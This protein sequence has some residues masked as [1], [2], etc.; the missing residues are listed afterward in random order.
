MI[1]EHRPL[2]NGTTPVSRFVRYHPAN[3]LSEIWRCG[4][5]LSSACHDSGR[6]TRA[7]ADRSA[8]KNKYRRR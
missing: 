2:V 1:N 7:I 6:P 4:R 5:R 3:Q 8:R